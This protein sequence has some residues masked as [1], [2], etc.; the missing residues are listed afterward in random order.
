MTMTI[1]A[2]EVVAAFAIHGRLVSC[3]RYGNG[4]IN[5][6]YLVVT[7]QS[8]TTV[9]YIL[10]RINER[11]FPD[12]DAV[13]RNIV[14]VTACLAQACPD[15]RRRLSLIPTRVGGDW[16]IDATG[17]RWRCYPFIEGTRTVEQV[18]RPEEAYATARTFGAFQR[19]LA[20][21]EG[22]PLAEVI[23]GFH[24]TPR[25]FA[26][27]EAAI[28]ADAHGRAAEVEAEIRW[29][30]DQRGWIGAIV[31]GLA[32]GS[33]PRRITHNDTKIN[34]V[35]FAADSDEGICVIDLDTLMPGSSLY[36]F[37]DL[38]RTATA[39]AAEDA[40]DLDRVDS[41]ADCYQALVSGWLDELGDTLTK[42]ERDL[43][44]LAGALMTYEVGIRFLTDF[45][46]GD[47]YFRIKRPGHNRDRARNQIAM[48]KAIRG[49]QG[50]RVA[51]G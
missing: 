10:Q 7:D 14:G 16:Y 43:L 38:V 15:P 5:D 23:P 47:T 51:V 13:M 26:A 39:T 29:A 1:T 27:L 17:G 18:T 28:A 24:D 3:E 44:P 21:Y 50:V 45:L 37:G 20:R 32:S 25:R 36:D 4:H 46:S 31:A 6:T 8:G 42:A 30:L 40:T 12:P 34:N 41:D 48:V 9:R 22:Q 11:V 35:L 49:R 33:L 2:P 19:G